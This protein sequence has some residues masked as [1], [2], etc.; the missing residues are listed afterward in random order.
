MVNII[1]EICKKEL[2]TRF[3]S[4]RVLLPLLIPIGIPILVF[5]PEIQEVM[6]QTEPESELVSFLLFLLIPVMVTTLV[7]ITAFINEIR[8][9]TIKS[10]LVAPVS[11]GEILLGKSLAC[12]VVGLLVEVLISGLILISV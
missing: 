4:K 9:K 7:G 12:I 3:G 11:E 10:I 6:S 2:K 1:L 8:W 5:I